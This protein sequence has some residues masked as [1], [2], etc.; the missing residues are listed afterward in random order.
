ME[1]KLFNIWVISSSLHLYSSESFIKLIFIWNGRF[2]HT[3]A[4]HVIIGTL[5]RAASG[6]YL[7]LQS[8]LSWE[9]KREQPPL[10]NSW[11]CGPQTEDSWN[12]FQSSPTQLRRVTILRLGF[13]HHTWH[14][15]LI[16]QT[17]IR[18]RLEMQRGWSPAI[19]GTIFNTIC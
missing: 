19:E 10:E 18:F 2:P 15:F 4:F 8:T 12:Y 7:Y 6:V 1:E 14:K 9:S 13:S 11:R 3:S 17:I 16:P 5:N